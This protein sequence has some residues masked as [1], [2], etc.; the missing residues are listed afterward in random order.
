MDINKLKELINSNPDSILNDESK[1]TQI[2]KDPELVRLFLE[3]KN[4]KSLKVTIN[5]QPTFF[6]HSVYPLRRNPSIK[7]VR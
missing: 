7:M 4:T 1:L 2:A 5:G 3:S 6:V